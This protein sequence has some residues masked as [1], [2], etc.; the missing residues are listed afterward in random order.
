MIVVTTPTGNIWHHVVSGLVGAGEAVRV[1]ARDPARLL[2]EVREKV[3]IVQGSMDDAAVLSKACAGVDTLFWCVPQSNQ[4]ADV[5][6]YYLQFTRPACMAVTSQGVKRVVAI[7]SGGRG[8]ARNAG[9]IS[10]L[11]A[12]E[13]MFE[14]TG[15]DFR[16]LR[17]GAFME[18]LLWQVEPIKRKGMFFYPLDG[19]V[20]M[21]VCA[22]RDIAGSATTMLRDRSWRGQ[23]GLA[24]HGKEDLSFNEMAAIMSEVLGRPIRFQEVPGGAYKA[25]LIEHGSSEAFAQSLVD[26]FAEVG[27]GIY[28]AE[29]RMPETTTPTTFRQWCV[30]VLARA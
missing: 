18:N 28:Q 20:K 14:K 9:P 15:V 19:N 30:E 12:M 8:R 11:H 25:L 26:M 1:V 2:P 7:S 22:V 27:Q 6:E 21:P 17:C 23:G 4:Q 24:V 13:A 3:E 16:A 10:A 29:P 5:T